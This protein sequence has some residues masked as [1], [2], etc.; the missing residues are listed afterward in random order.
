MHGRNEEKA[1]GHNYPGAESL[2]GHQITVGLRKVPIMSQVL[3]SI[4]YFCLRKTSGCNMGAPSNLV[5]PLGPLPLRPHSGCA[6][7]CGMFVLLYRLQD[8]KF[9]VACKSN[10]NAGPWCSSDCL[11]HWY[12]KRSDRFS[13]DQWFLTL[14]LPRPLQVI[15]LFFKSPWQ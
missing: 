4:Q 6:T 7:V 3:S 8:N 13:L 1:S 11:T 9:R 12:V 14:S 15:V 5:T 10:W 2:W